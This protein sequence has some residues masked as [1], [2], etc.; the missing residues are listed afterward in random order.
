LQWKYLQPDSW[1][2]S[3]DQLALGGECREMSIQAYACCEMVVTDE[4]RFG[5]LF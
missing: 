2:H 1:D 5:G 3:F 4:V